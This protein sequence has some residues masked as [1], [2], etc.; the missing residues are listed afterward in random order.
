MFDH[1]LAL[2]G[3]I[4]MLD[5]ISAGRLEIGFAMA[6]LQYEFRRF[7]AEMDASRDRFESVSTAVYLISQRWK[8]RKT[9]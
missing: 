1:P 5:G 8:V 4:G 3:E 7:G 9:S 2:V 6:L